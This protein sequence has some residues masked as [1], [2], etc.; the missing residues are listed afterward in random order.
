MTN[1]TENNPKRT[2]VGAVISD[3]MEKTIVVKVPRSY[4]HPIYGKVVRTDKTYKVHDEKE[5]SGVGDKV[6]IYEGP[7]ISK[8]KY[9]YLLRVLESATVK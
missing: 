1:K 6:E 2:M 4:I 3:K 8:T 9:M 7:H 5:L